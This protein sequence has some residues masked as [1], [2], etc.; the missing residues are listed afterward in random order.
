MMIRLFDEIERE[1][2]R[3]SGERAWNRAYFHALK[4]TPPGLR[5]K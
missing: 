3:L 4:I 1:V 5:L 2:E